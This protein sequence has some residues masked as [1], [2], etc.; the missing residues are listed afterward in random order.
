V[1]EFKNIHLY[2]SKL[3]DFP[4]YKNLLIENYLKN[5]ST[6]EYKKFIN[7]CDANI[8]RDILNYKSELLIN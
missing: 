5:V 3:I 8:L 2:L 4:K 6:E 7:E 1:D